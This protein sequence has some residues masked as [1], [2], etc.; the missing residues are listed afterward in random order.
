M[1]TTNPKQTLTHHR[2]IQKWVRGRAGQP[3]IQRVPDQFGVTRPRL[4]LSFSHVSKP[5]T[6]SLDEAVS[7]VSWTAWLAELDR[8]HLALRVSGE[9]QYELVERRDLN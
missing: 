4:T 2:D 8:Q 1:M 5:G 6:P 3:A 9:E 7:P